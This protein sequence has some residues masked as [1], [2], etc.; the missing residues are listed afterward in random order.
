MAEAGWHIWSLYLAYGLYYG[1]S[2]GTLKAF[3]AD[4]VDPRLRGTAYGLHAA[5]I[6]VLDLPASVIAGVLW[7]GVGS[8]P[9]LGPAAPFWFGAI[10]ACAAALLLGLLMRETQT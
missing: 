7:S 10:T 2:Y 4:L 6:G 3:I 5:V 1:L 9:G 8:W